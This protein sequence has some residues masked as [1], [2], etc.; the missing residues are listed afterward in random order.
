MR[1]GV[2]AHRRANPFFHLAEAGGLSA[3]VIT[4]GGIITHLFVPDRHNQLDDVVLG[5]DRLSSYVEP[6]PFFG[7]MA[8][9]VA[10]RISG[11]RFEI[12]GRAYQLERNDPPNHL[13][14]GSRGFDKQVWNAA[15]VRRTDG[16]VLLAS[17]ASAPTA[18][19]A[20]PAICPC[21]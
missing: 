21:P 17:S 18:R 12:D 3:R 11:G 20:I 2:F 7:A 4:L 8:G 6:H 16:A 14:G 10:G 13:H 15:P 5:F 1:V 19:P 9:R